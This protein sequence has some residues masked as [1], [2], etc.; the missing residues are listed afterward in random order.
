MNRK[1]GERDVEV[2]SPVVSK[3]I[4]KTRSSPST[5][6]CLDCFGSFSSRSLLMSHKIHKCKGK[7]VKGPIFKCKY[8]NAIFNKKKGWAQHV[9]SNCAVLKEK[10]R[11]KS[12]SQSDSEEENIS[13]HNSNNGEDENLAT[14]HHGDLED[15]REDHVSCKECGHKLFT[16]ENFERHQQQT[17][18]TGETIRLPSNLSI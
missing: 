16:Q 1:D 3:Q 13:A 7:S 2:H 5:H 14:D 18:H 17:G 8:C 11:R 6:T 4:K 9:R 10:A 12:K 15:T